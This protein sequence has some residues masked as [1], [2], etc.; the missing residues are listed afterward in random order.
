MPR[1]KI[2]DLSATNIESL[3]ISSSSL[4]RLRAFILKECKTLRDL[5][6]LGQLKG[7]E[8]LDLSYSSMI[9]L[10]CEMQNLHQ[11]KRLDL[12]YIDEGLIIPPNILYG[13]SSLVDLRL[14]MTE[15]TWAKQ[16]EQE[17]ATNTTH[18]EVARLKDLISLEIYIHDINCVEEHAPHW[19][20][21]KLE[22]F[23][24]NI[25]QFPLNEDLPCAR[26]MQIDGGKNYPDG[27]KVIAAYTQGLML[28]HA[29]HGELVSQL[30]GDLN[31]WEGLKILFFHSCWEIE[32]IVDCRH[33]GKNALENIEH[34]NLYMLP[35]LKKLFEQVSKVCLKKLRKIV[36]RRCNAL[37]S[38]FSSEMVEDLGALQ[39]LH[40]RN[41]DELEEIIEGEIKKSST[42]DDSKPKKVDEGPLP[43]L[44]SLKL[45]ELPKLRS[46]IRPRT[47]P[48]PALKHY[49]EFNCPNLSI[50]NCPKITR[51]NLLPSP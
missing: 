9:T 42:E 19:P 31:S 46:I 25:G 32:C 34:L 5:R 12:S 13:L 44:F 49:H 23:K 1:L 17:A 41:C 10:P 4:P 30:V 37:K 27:V 48:L 39:Y 11:L 50:P 45:S 43:N 7:L 6:F 47:L 24:I 28:L 26:Q 20:W 33:D 38:L 29:V 15:V 51:R 14:M 2:L 18:G 35:K 8:I 40:V 36:V 3:V 22:K 16:S 21:S